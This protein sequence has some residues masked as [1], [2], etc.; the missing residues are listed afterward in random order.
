MYICYIWEL[1][2]IVPY[3][4]FAKFFLLKE[5]CHF[6]RVKEW[7]KNHIY[8]LPIPWLGGGIKSMRKAN[9]A[10]PPRFSF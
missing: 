1:A 9:G 8:G 10:T 3:E 4:I 6:P 7:V 2:K 5:K